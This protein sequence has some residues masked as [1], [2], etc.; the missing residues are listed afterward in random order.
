MQIASLQ[1]IYTK[2]FFSANPALKNK[3]IH[4]IFLQ[5]RAEEFNYIIDNISFHTDFKSAGQL[6]VT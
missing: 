2:Y 3:T 6:Y 5:H 1:C 4:E